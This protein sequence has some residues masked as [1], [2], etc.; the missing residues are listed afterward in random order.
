MPVDIKEIHV[1][2]TIDQSRDTENQSGNAADIKE[3][4]DAIIAECVEQVM[5]ILNMKKER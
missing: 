5:E 2:V 1:K 3:N 4:K